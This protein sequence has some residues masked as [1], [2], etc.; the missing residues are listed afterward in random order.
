M[1]KLI[2]KSLG[3]TLAKSVF[4]ALLGVFRGGLSMALS[5][6]KNTL[7]AAFTSVKSFN[8][9]GVNTSRAIGLGYRDSIAYTQTLI[10]RTQRLSALYGV[11]A[12]KIA[13]IQDSLA[14]ATGKAI[15]LSNAQAEYAT[16]I[17]KMLGDGVLDEYSKAII[18]SMGGSVDAAQ[19]YAIGAY[20]KATRVGLSAAEFSNKV[21]QN[22]SMA[23]RVSFRGGIDG[24]TKMTALSEKLNFNLQ[25]MEASANVFRDD[26]Q[27]A[28]ESSAKLQALGG[29]AAM[30]GSNP[31][32]MMYE[33]MYD[34]ESY[35]ERITKMVKG[36]AEF[37]AATGI[38][39]IKSQNQAFLREYSKIL[40]ISYD[41]L[42]SMATNQAK[43]AFA[44]NR[45][46]AAF[47][48]NIAGGDEDFKNFIMNK[49]QW[50]DQEQ[51]FEIV[52]PGREDN[53]INLNEVVGDDK[54]LNALKQEWRNSTLTETEAFLQGA[55]EIT[56]IDE[57]IAGVMS[58][59]GAMLAEKLMPYLEVASMWLSHAAPKIAS[60]IG[61][62]LQLLLTPGFWKNIGLDF[63][64]LLMGGLAGLL[65]IYLMTRS[66]IFTLIGIV[67]AIADGLGGMLRLIPGL[68]GVGKAVQS[69]A[70]WG[71]GRGLAEAAANAARS[72]MSGFKDQQAAEAQSAFLKD[73]GALVKEV[74]GV[75]KVA[76]DYA[77]AVE[78]G[79]QYDYIG[80][81]QGVT[82]ENY[83]G[84]GS[85]GFP[86]T[87]ARAQGTVTYN[88]T[89]RNTTVN[90]NRYT[91]STTNNNTQTVNRNTTNTTNAHPTT[92]FQA[93]QGASPAYANYQDAEGMSDPNSLLEMPE[94][95]MASMGGGGGGLFNLASTALGLYLPYKMLKS[96]MKSMFGRGATNAANAA[97]KGSY[98]GRRMRLARLQA[99][100]SMRNLRAFGQYTRD[101]YSAIR[102]TGAGRIRSAFNALRGPGIREN[103]S[104]FM[105]T[106]R[107][108]SGNWAGKIMGNITTNSAKSSFARQALQG[109][110]M[111]KGLGI[112][113]LGFGAG[114]LVDN[115]WTNKI[116]PSKY[117]S[118]EHYAANALSSAL[119]YGGTG[120]SI[121]SLFG[122]WGTAIG[123]ALGGLYG[124]IK[125]LFNAKAE[126]KK[127]EERKKALAQYNEQKRQFHDYLGQYGTGFETAAFNPT[128]FQDSVV[129]SMSAPMAA[130]LDSAVQG[131]DVVAAPV[132]QSEYI[133]SQPTTQVA[134]NAQQTIKVS[135]I[136]VKVNGTLKLDAGNGNVA[137]LDMNKLLED[138]AFVKKLVE[139]VFNEKNVQSNNGRSVFDTV[140]FRN[141]GVPLNGVTANIT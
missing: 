88:T 119:K 18:R 108:A 68:E 121:G 13:A 61:R 101:A 31:L 60:I 47:F 122:P 100:R 35:T 118:T 24:I 131:S 125:G 25:S 86:Q 138:R 8:Q 111:F 135:D 75:L 89:N 105:R 22:L 109:A 54:K 70:K 95:N 29:G 30:Y 14:K 45:L 117:G 120:A 123:G 44:K 112:G 129:G 12:D 42:A 116:D 82:G 141:G 52:L 40:N 38:A 139:V 39:E 94:E 137:Q 72:L 21:A 114:K 91:T 74:G 66:P 16:A 73:A 96:G 15:M 87:E 3:N 65:Q 2:L 41:E 53:P 50:N 79:E 28:I 33:S 37:N 80:A 67:S 106:Y 140:S 56:S 127:E 113:A 48:D 17:N 63:A 90:N 107:G 77:G 115:L 136:T 71:D 49:A 55:R 23:N 83:R 99:G 64:S 69:V 126:A 20:A 9:M 32:A 7:N 27:T 104:I 132:G 124:G 10:T 133:Y 128:T 78:R 5:M 51:R 110:K 62:G 85:Y 34:M 11:T 134:Q 92:I 57:R 98:L 43:E 93:V 130:A 76:N 19:K 84:S 58:V 46:G 102:G 97:S 81:L 59:V 6:F 1:F 103:G 4:G 26:I 36:M